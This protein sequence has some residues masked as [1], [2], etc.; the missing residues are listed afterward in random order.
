MHP[1]ALGLSVQYPD[2]YPDAVPKFSIEV[3]RG[4]LEENEI[5]QLVAE[6]EKVV[7]LP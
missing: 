5:A 3:E 1:V 7:R 6:L 4:E 2:E